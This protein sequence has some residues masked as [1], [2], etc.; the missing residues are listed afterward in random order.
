MLASPPGVKTSETVGER[1]KKRT[2]N[3]RIP[4]ELETFMLSQGK[5]ETYAKKCAGIVRRLK[6]RFPTYGIDALFRVAKA[7]D[8]KAHLNRMKKEHYKKHCK[9][10]CK[11]HAVKWYRKMLQART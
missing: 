1:T 9:S 2:R 3:K 5:K 11:M 6:E 4:C 8:S 10:N 7:E